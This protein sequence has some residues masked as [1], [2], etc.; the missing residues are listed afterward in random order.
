M[1]RFA[2]SCDQGHG[3]DAWFSSGA[4][5][6]EQA[7]A[8]VITCPDC[9]SD[10]V[11]KA[12][13]APAV[14]RGKARST[15]EDGPEPGGKPREGEGRQTYAV[16]ESLREHLQANADDV[17]KAFPDEARKIHYGEAEARSIYGEA[18]LEEAKALQEEGVPVLQLP[19]L[20][21]ERN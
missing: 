11:E 7:E 10:R 19:P 13:M 5:Y 4:S 20:P 12:P 3:F 1:I 17:G 9:G 14:L 21:K 18:S 16:L 2:L 15:A 6:D 8:G